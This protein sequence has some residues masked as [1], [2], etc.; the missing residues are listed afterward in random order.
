MNSSFLN[1]LIV[2]VFYDCILYWVC[3]LIK[4]Q[5]EGAIWA[6]GAHCEHFWWEYLEPFFCSFF[7][8][9]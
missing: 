4:K 6:M 5:V 8:P 2:P 9:H 1:V 7:A 3:W